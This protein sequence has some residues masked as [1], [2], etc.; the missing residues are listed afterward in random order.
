[1]QNKLKFYHYKRLK[2]LEHL[3]Q[4]GNYLQ[5]KVWFSPVNELNDPFEG[6]FV[7]KPSETRIKELSNIS[8]N[9]YRLPK[10]PED[11]KHPKYNDSYIFT[12]D[13]IFYINDGDYIENPTDN[14]EEI[15]DIL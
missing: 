3:Y 1:M 4:L 8:N 5:E 11:F 12:D 10:I 6:E 7:Y 13:K 9:I 2:N 15:K 14:Y